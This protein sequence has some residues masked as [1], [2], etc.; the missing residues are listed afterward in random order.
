MAT[1]CL[2]KYIQTQAHLCGISP[3]FFP[4]ASWLLKTR[5]VLHASF[6]GATILKRLVIQGKVWRSLSVFLL[7]AC[8]AQ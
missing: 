2:V 4:R 8:G 3:L 5:G 1:G 7:Q 6:F